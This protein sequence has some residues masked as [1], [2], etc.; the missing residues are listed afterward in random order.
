MIAVRRV[1]GVLALSGSLL[2]SGCD[3]DGAY[4][5]PLPGHAV[6]EDNAFEVTAEFEDVLN[7]VPRSPVLVDDVT[8][9]EVV[10]VDRVGWHARVVLRIRKDV[11]LPDN[12]L[13]RIRQTSLLGEKYVSLE[14]PPNP[15]A[16]L[17]GEGDTIP[18]SETGR[19]PEVEEV[20]G[21]LSFLL[22]GGGVGQLATITDELNQVM[23]GRTDRLQKLL[24]DLGSVVATVDEQKG[25]IIRAMESLDKLAGTLN[26][27]KETIAEALDTMG[28]AI[29]VLADQHQELVTMLTSLD[30]LGVV[31]TRVIRAS[32]DDML[33][34]LRSLQ[35]LLTQLNKAG[36][37][38]P[39]GLSLLLS[40]PFPESAQ[41][42]VM[43]DFAN[44]EIRLDI[45]LENFF[46]P[47]SVIPDP[48]QVLNDVQKCLQSGN[49]A[50]AACARVL[51]SLNLLGRLK[52]ACAKPVNAGNP[53]CKAINALPS[54]PEIPGLPGL[55]QIPGLPLD[56]LLGLRMAATG[57]G[58]QRMGSDLFEE[59][60]T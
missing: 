15:S 23:T 12:A 10:E 31:G 42:I 36:K 45:N 55:P 39:N 3:F 14:D 46:Q 21:A 18:L 8:V 43:G 28:P 47:G 19:N 41:D 48:D 20:L 52:T 38:L 40:F 11:E 60:L 29:S 37:S 56:G 6:D 57:S 59:G 50:S 17:L 13:A 27:G 44:T 26:A 1:L 24:R 5:L 9:G 22:S 25:D 54:L 33:S 35:P 7:V 4:D 58:G 2:V 51:A 30:R 16:E 49:L 34:M 32:K 53:V